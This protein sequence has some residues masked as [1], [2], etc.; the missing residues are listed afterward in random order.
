MLS[1]KITQHPKYPDRFETFV[2]SEIGKIII[3]DWKQL[4]A[5]GIEI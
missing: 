3:I 1:V 2:V 4:D 5:R